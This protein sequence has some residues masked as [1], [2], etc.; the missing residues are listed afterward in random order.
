MAARLVSTKTARA[1]EMRRVLTRWARSGLTQREFAQREDIPLS[2]ITWWRHVFRHA[3]G[4]AERVT[5]RRRRRGR[6]R[7]AAAPAF[8]EVKM[9]TVVPAA[10]AP[11]EVVVRS[12]QVIRVPREFDAAS[13]RAVVAALESPC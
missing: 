1:R 13:L 9:A 11:L 6:T 5:G 4:Q 10:A 3:G 12:G 7:P 2:T 8:I